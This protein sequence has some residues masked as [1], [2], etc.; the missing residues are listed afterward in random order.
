MPKPPRPCKAIRLTEKDLKRL[1]SDIEKTILKLA[2][3]FGDVDGGIERMLDD[4]MRDTR[5]WAA[6]LR[7]YMNDRATEE[8]QT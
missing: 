4:F 1:D 3:R 5:Q 2:Q 7:E 8:G 6:D